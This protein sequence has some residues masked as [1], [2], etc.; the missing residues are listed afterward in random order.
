M[1]RPL[2]TK[3]VED[4]PEID[5]LSDTASGGDNCGSTVESSVASLSPQN[6]LMSGLMTYE[7]AE[8]QT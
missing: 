7:R 3:L 2:L 4:S 1:L 8:A 5:Q 6:A